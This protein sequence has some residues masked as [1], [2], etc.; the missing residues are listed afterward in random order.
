MM[1]RDRKDAGRR[2]SEKLVAYAANPECLVLA[3]P[4]GGVPVAYEVAQALDLPLD[5]LV[6]R[7]LGVPGRSELALGAI[8]TGS[9]VVLNEDV[10]SALRL[11]KECIS[12][13]IDL[14]RAELQRRE[15]IYRADRAAPEIRGR[16]V[17][18]V[19]DGMATGATMRAAARALSEQH[20]ARL[21]IAV[22]TGAPDTCAAL[23]SE[24]DEL[25]CLAM[26]DPYIAVGCW[27][28]DF[29]QTSD[30]EVRSLLERANQSVAKTSD[31]PGEFA[32]S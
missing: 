17:I 3:L 2:L 32:S 9:G 25:V 1:F 27:Y 16:T 24:V 21:V 12:G 30:S 7:K 26:P 18:L 6:V 23:V 19:D 8:A 10:I 15:S 13:V 22:P 4:R 5:V 28:D 20:P 31:L 29:R 11:S 14:E